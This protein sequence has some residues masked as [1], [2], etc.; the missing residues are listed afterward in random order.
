MKTLEIT[1]LLCQLVNF[2]F[3][4]AELFFD[5]IVVVLDHCV[6][7]YGVDEGHS[8]DAAAEEEGDEVDSYCCLA[9]GTHSCHH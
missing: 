6:N 5:V 2:F 8:E 4:T 1:Y 3:E 9:K 7:H